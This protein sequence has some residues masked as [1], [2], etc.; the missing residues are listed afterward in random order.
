M[1]KG[2]LFFSFLLL[3]LIVWGQNGMIG[4]GFGTNDWSTT[5]GFNSGVETTRIFTTTPNGTGDRYFRLV[6]NWSGNYTQFGPSGC[7][8]TDWTNPGVPYN[9]STCGSGAFKINVPNTTDNY[10]F[11]TPNGNTATKFVYFRV[12]GTVRSVTNVSYTNFIVAGDPYTVNATLDGALSTGQSVYLR[13]TKDNFSTSTVVEMSGSGTAYSATISGAFNTAS[14]EVKYY[15]FT[16]GNGL[17][18]AGSDANFYTINR[19]NGGSNYYYNVLGGGGTCSGGTATYTGPNTWTLVPDATRDVVID[20]DLT[21]DASYDMFCCS[22]TVN[23]G[24]T[25]TINTGKS[26]YVTN[27]L[28]INGTL[29]INSGGSLVQ[30]NDSATNTYGSS[31]LVK[32]YRTSTDYELNDYTYWSSPI[33]GETLSS[34]LAASPQSKI[35]K[36]STGTYSDRFNQTASG[37]TLGF[38]QTQGTPDN[39]DDTND[40]WLN[41]TG[42]MTSGVGYIAQGDLA[43]APTSNGQTVEFTASGADGNLNNGQISVPVVL[44]EYHTLGQSGADTYNL[45]QNLIGNPYPSA[46]DLVILTNDNAS[47]LTGTYYFWT[48]KTALNSSVSGPYLQNFS[49][50]DYVTYTAGTGGSAGSCSGCTAPDQYVDS[51]QGFFA[52]VKAAGNVVFKNSQRKLGNNLGFYKTADNS[53]KDRMWVNLLASNGEFRQILVGFIND[54]SDDYNPYYDGQRLENGV[55]FDFYSYIPSQPEVRLAVN[56]LGTFDVSKVVPLGLEITENGTHQISL[57]RAEGIFNEGQAIYLKDNLTG[58]LHD[59]STGSYSF[60]QNTVD[61]LNDRFEIVF[62][63]TMATDNITAD[64]FAVY[65]NPSAGVFQIN[66]RVQG[67]MQVTV[68]DITGKL[69]KNL[70]FDN[71]TPATIDLSNVVSGIY[72]AKI[73]VNGSSVTKKLV[74]E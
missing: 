45:N 2:L 48:H 33:N 16:S 69:I 1:K 55:G 70:T 46:V 21:I 74:V 28:T 68:T 27:G 39:Y 64:S 60:T 13:Y 26:V 31:S 66:S 14:A 73:S 8:D 34:A 65:P 6:R 35:Y 52:N 51:C 11:K 42:T 67:A 63:S 47:V 12:Q 37:A 4:S 43:V 19:N 36:F 30:L 58:T 53:Q 40:E 49:N 7:T 5:D 38:P 61:H 22:L 71:L 56:G 59:M 50:N 9:L 20:Y 23:A 3:T 32:V 54:S 18:I 17:T 72:L 44:D 62:T 57:D 10:I 41:F 29:I 15:V 24:K 25:L